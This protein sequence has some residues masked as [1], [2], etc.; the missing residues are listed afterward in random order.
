MASA[1]TNRPWSNRPEVRQADPGTP[2]VLPGDAS[3]AGLS[4]SVAHAAI[5]LVPDAEVFQFVND[6]ITGRDH[7]ALQKRHAGLWDRAR[8]RRS[9]GARQAAG[10]R[11]AW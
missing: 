2:F 1:W 4:T 7:L 8:R 6:R 5:A 9:A 11:Q 3:Q 10:R